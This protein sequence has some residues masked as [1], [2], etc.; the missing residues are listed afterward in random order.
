MATTLNK[1]IRALSSRRR[2]TVEVRAAELIAEEL[3]LRDL[4]KAH[5]LTQTR[6]AETLGLGQDGI[7]RIEQRSDLL[8]STLRSYVEAM[9]GK[10][11]LVAEFPDRPPVHLSGLARMSKDGDAAPRRHVVR[12]KPRSSLT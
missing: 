6:M 9:G 11:H 3:S 8:I 4:R 10:L 7:S 5:E 2:K 12:T 1:K